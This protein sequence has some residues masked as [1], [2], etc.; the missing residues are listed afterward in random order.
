VGGDVLYDDGLVRVDEGGLTVARYYFPFATA[1]RVAFEQIQAVHVRR[2]GWLTGRLRGW[3]TTVPG[4]WLP[5]DL[6]RFRRTVMICL[7]VGGRV[8]PSFT[9]VDPDAVVALLRT[10]ITPH[11]GATE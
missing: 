3:G 10:R 6:G 8:Q 7:D 2:M 5:L 11:Q 4:S 1:K 9:P